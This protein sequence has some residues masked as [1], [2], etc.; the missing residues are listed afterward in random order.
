VRLSPTEEE[1]ESYSKIDFT[2]QQGMVRTSPTAGEDVD[3]LVRAMNPGEEAREVVLDTVETAPG[4]GTVDLSPSDEQDP[5]SDGKVVWSKT[6]SENGQ[7][8]YKTYDRV[9]DRTMPY[10]IPHLTCRNGWKTEYRI[11]RENPAE[12]VFI[13]VFDRLGMMLQRV[14]IPFDTQRQASGDLADVLSPSVLQN[15]AYARLETDSEN[16]LG[17]YVTYSNVIDAPVKIPI[18]SRP[19]Y[20]SMKLF[21]LKPVGEGGTGI[22]IVN[23]SNVENQI[24]YEMRTVNGVRLFRGNLLLQPGEKWLTTVDQLTA[25]MPIERT[26]T[27]TIHAHFQVEAIAIQADYQPLTLY[28]HRILGNKLDQVTETYLSIPADRDAY[29]MFANYN[30]GAMFLLFE[31]YDAEGNRQGRFNMQLGERLGVNRFEKASVQQIFD[32]GVDNPDFDAITMFR[33][34]APAPFYG[35]EFAADEDDLAPFAL[36]IPN[37]YENP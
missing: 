9:N 4:Y 18:E 19:I 27:L 12:P 20:G 16:V 17:G 5:R 22:A 15:G 11:F 36:P 28:G 3:V 14:A 34:T 24:L 37:V 8:L 1:A 2:Q 13:D 23:T 25:G 26:D 10:V 21:D 7:L 31:G 29:Y 35:I 6:V 32:N 33:V 30:D